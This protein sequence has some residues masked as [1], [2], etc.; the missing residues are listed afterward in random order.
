MRV[1]EAALVVASVA[2]A[3]E[4]PLMMKGT[5]CSRGNC[6]PLKTSSKMRTSIEVQGI[7]PWRGLGRRPNLALLHRAIV[8]A[9]AISDDD[10]K[11]DRRRVQH[12]SSVDN[13]TRIP[14]TGRSQ[15]ALSA[16]PST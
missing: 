14:L 7:G 10:N 11:D 3:S 2:Q 5:P 13:R 8:R 4:V 9:Q 1:G 15:S 12:R 16:G 6:A